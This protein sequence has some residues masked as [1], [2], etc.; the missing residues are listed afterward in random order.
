MSAPGQATSSEAHSVLSERSDA[1]M[2]T[3][4]QAGRFNTAVAVGKREAGG[5][6]LCGP[7]DKNEM[8]R[9]SLVAKQ[10]TSKL[11]NEVS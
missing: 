8:Q 2:V 1:E 9:Q 3:I 11:Q 6:H 10:E 5:Q 4:L 7:M